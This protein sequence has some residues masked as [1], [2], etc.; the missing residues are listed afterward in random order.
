MLGGTIPIIPP[1][2][3]PYA[4]L[5]IEQGATSDSI[6]S[7]TSLR[8]T[9]S[10]VQLQSWNTHNPPIPNAPAEIQNIID[11]ITTESYNS[12][13]S[14]ISGTIG[15]RFWGTPGNSRAVEYIANK[16]Q[17]YGLEVELHSFSTG[18]PNVIGTLKGGSIHNN[19][20]IIVGAHL[21]TYPI[22]SPGADDDGSGI[23]AVLE[24]ARV[25][26]QY[27]YNYTIM[28]VAFNAEEQGLVGSEAFVNKLFQENVSV[29]IM[30][31]FD[32]ILWDSPSAP[33]NWKVHIVHN[34]GDSAWFAQHAEGIGQ[35]VI[36]APVQA[37]LQPLWLSSD[38]KPFW[39]RNI[40]AVWFFEYEGWDNPWIHSSEDYLGQPEYSTEL[41]ALTTKTAAAAVADFATIVS[42]EV[43]FPEIDFIT[44][45]YGSYLAPTNPFEVVLSIDDA[46]GDVEYVELSIDDGPWINVTAGLNSTHCTYMFDAT[47]FYGVTRMRARAYDVEGWIAET[48]TSVVFDK[49]IYCSIHAPQ[50][51]DIL[52]EGVEY[53]I[54]VNV[55]DPDNRYIPTIQVRVN[56]SLWQNCYQYIANQVYYFNWTAQGTGRVRM[57]ARVIDGNGRQNSSMVTVT[58]T[59]Y[60]PIISGVQ[61]LPYRPLDSDSIT[62]TAT[63]SQDVKGSGINQVLLFYSVDYSLWTPRLM[64]VVSGDT[65]RV[66]LDPF[67]A[68]AR[69]RFY[70]L[71]RDNF[72]N[73]VVDN[74]NGVYYTFLVELNPTLLIA[75]GAIVGL[76]I[77]SL[78]VFYFLRYR[79]RPQRTPT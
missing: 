66:I 43:G 14:Y 21:D 23:S 72:D 51:D 61:F 44:P 17:S 52:D 19:A 54:W 26:S 2:Q 76:I 16:F 32:M 3:D 64:R 40:P 24:M 75:G 42:T 56:A 55:T 35:S 33:E 62:V 1:S 18:Q 67:P 73:V 8:S 38:H 34:G 22:A 50:D 48:S 27:R 68:G 30:Y 57:E 15:S 4:G 79:R 53:T 29:T 45:S 28:F 69:V 11:Q 71:A 59:S 10:N 63:I 78:G 36:D 9:G 12:K 6:T 13:L 20:T 49:G 74:N 31:N 39:D 60:P 7:P 58:V 77:A 37:N 46:L 25:L 47:S 70:I 5:R 41:G 65:Y